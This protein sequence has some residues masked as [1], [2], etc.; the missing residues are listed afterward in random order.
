M[1]ELIAKAALDGQGPVTWGGLVLS[2]LP[3][4][5]VWSIAPFPGE[6]LTPVL[7]ALGLEFPAPGHSHSAGDLR[8]IWTGRDQAFL[9]GG[10]PPEG[11]AAAV[12]DQSGAWTGFS[13][14]GAGGEAALAR[15]VTPDLRLAAFP[16][17]HVVRTGLNHIPAIILRE[18]ETEF[19]IRVFRSMARSAWAELVEVLEHLAA[20][21][22]AVQ[23]GVSAPARTG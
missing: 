1:A 10:R 22:A 12:T 21:A 9:L 20:R 4:A 2:V 11:L 16:V 7:E 23:G 18:G 8:L 19:H 14:A 13:L 3:P 5:P 6:D 15:M 17:G